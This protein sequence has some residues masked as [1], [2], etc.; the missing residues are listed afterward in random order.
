[1]ESRFQF[2][3][4]NY[5]PYFQVEK[6]KLLSRVLAYCATLADLIGQFLCFI[7][8]VQIINVRN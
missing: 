3:I 8:A 6:K 2:S 5:H 1:M 7:E 4:E